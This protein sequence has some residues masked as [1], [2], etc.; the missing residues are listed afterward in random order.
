MKKNSMKLLTAFY[1]SVFLLAQAT[2]LNAQD[3]K[4]I[5][6]ICPMYC[7]DEASSKEGATCSVCRMELVD[8]AVVENPTTHKL[9]FPR[10]AFDLMNKAKDVVV[11]DVRTEGEYE[12]EDG[13][14]TNAV[15]IPIADLEKRLKEL[16]PHKGKTIIAYCSHG[17]RSARAAQ[18]LS[19][20]G[21][22]AFSLVGGTTKWSREK[23]PTIVE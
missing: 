7:T 6:Y 9:I 17:I 18:L 3:K 1:V 12:G 21:F 10:Q 14:L 15:L 19:R 20:H 4:S 5:T 16:E 22:T 13:H 8:K 23:F 2:M 11:L